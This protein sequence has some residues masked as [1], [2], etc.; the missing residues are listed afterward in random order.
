MKTTTW[1][2]IGFLAAS[3]L[4][5]ATG[6]ILDEKVIELVFKNSTCMDFEE[7]HETEV[8]TTPEVVDVADDI[9]DALADQNLSRDDL[10]DAKLIGGTY[11]VTDFQHTHDWD[12]SGTITVRR[13]DI[14]DGPE[15]IVIYT[16]QSLED[17][18]PAPVTAQLDSAGVALFNRALDDYLNW[19]DPILEFSVNNGDV[20]PN[21]SAQ[22]PLEFDW[23]A[24]LKMYIIVDETYEVPDV[25]GG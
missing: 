7:Y 4:V 22:D 21:P 25:F 9:D 23:T 20:E 6:C 3:L 1:I 18:M 10:L 24:C 17:A 19:E 14:S 2:A 11:Q 12:I 13:T 16:S 5:G 15:T 8:F